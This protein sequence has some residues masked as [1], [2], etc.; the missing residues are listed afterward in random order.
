MTYY[1]IEYTSNF[2]VSA[3]MVNGS[4]RARPFPGNE[5]LLKGVN[6]AY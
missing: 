4:K 3:L 2:A 1:S 6:Y 5:A